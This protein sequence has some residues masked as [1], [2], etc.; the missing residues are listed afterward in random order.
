MS[1]KEIIELTELNQKL[2][3]ELA[4]LKIT[5]NQL[6]TIANNIPAFISYLDRD[7]RYTF[8]NEMYAK[9]FGQPVENIIGKH[10]KDVIGEKSY[11]DEVDKLDAAFS[12]QYVSFETIGD[13]PTTGKKWLAISYMPDFDDN[14]QVLGIVIFVRDTSQFKIANQE[15]NRHNARLESLLRISQFKTNNARQFLDFALKEAIQLT[16]SKIG[17]IFFYDENKK[18]FILNTWSN[19]AMKECSVL[20]PKTIYDLEQ[21]GCWGEAVRQRKPYINNHYGRDKIFEK[22][23]PA[24]HVKL[25]K[26]LTI[27]VFIDETI[28][29][30][31]GVANKENDYDNMDIRQLTLLMD[32]VWSMVEKF[33]Y[34]EELIKAKEKAEESDR[35]K[36]A[37]LHNISDEI[38]NPLN[39]II[40]FSDMI[41][42]PD[43]DPE[44]KKKYSAIVKTSSTQLLTIITDIIN[45]ASIEAG[46]EKIVEKEVNINSLIQNIH[47]QYNATIQA[48]NI[49]FS[50]ISSLSDEQTLVTAD[51]G[52]L[53][54][55]LANLINNSIKFT[56]QGHIKV[57]CKLKENFIEFCVEDTGVGID[58]HLHNKIFE[59]FNQS[60]NAIIKKHSGT[61]LGL[62]IS[63]SY[64]RLMGGQIW[65]TSEPGVG[66]NFYF[67]IPYKPII[68]INISNKNREKKPSPHTI[69]IAEDDIINFYVL[70]ECLLNLNCLIIHAETGLQAVEICKTNPSISLILMDVKM[71]LLNGF[72]AAKQIKEI[73]PEL[74]IIIQTAYVY[75]NDKDKAMLSHV[76]GYIEKPINRRALLELIRKHLKFR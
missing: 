50:V 11:N 52:K 12:G 2:Q 7:H 69:L 70:Q 21:T 47:I 64:I 32:K 41:G 13:F 60:E 56:S 5:N 57:N 51:E 72:D 9:N 74:P 76:D 49:Q 4:L 24:G 27:P 63:K 59:I 18:H 55:I 45:I 39:A 31:A 36:T 71:P 10:L 73:R 62:A 29:A 25:D 17:Y 46:Q 38:R 53:N 66:S 43:L 8:V 14:N 22:G 65:L 16:E 34:Q 44:K 33:Q 58:V 6:F 3:K 28:V 30:V 42:H 23:L 15:I 75:Y 19:E 61:G 48:K 1:N 67:T 35:L 37:F 40:G 54:Q 68:K 20:E 26:F